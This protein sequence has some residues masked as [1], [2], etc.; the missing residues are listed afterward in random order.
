M[1]SLKNKILRR[2]FVSKTP[3]KLKIKLFSPYQVFYE[4]EAIS[5]SAR[6]QTGPFDV[7][8]DHI[9]FF[10][11]LEAGE[12]SINT[13]TETKKYPIENGLIKINDNNIVLFANV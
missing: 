9:N 7:L 6:N 10:S 12:V 5:L 11:L 13:G 4:G 2:Y 3:K 8:Y 1:V